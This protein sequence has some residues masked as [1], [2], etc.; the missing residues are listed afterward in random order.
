MA[1]KKSM[2]YIFGM[3]TGVDVVNELLNLRLL[4]PGNYLMIFK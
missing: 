1:K 3:I 2:D 4:N